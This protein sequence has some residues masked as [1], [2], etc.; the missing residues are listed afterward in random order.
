[1]N[2]FDATLKIKDY[3]Y[4]DNHAFLKINGE[5]EHSNCG[6]SILYS[7]NKI[8]NV[9]DY[10]KITKLLG[11]NIGIHKLPEEEVISFRKI[12]C[13]V[14][15]DKDYLKNSV[16]NVN[17]KEYWNFLHKEFQFCDVMSY[18]I[19][20]CLENYFKVKGNLYDCKIDLLEGKLNFFKDKKILEIGAGYGYLP[21]ILKENS[22]NH[23][24]YYADIVKRFDHDNFIDVD[25]Y[26]LGK[27]INEKFDVIVMFDV[28]QHLGFKVIETYF[29][30]FKNLLND[31]GK[32]I[33]DTPTLCNTTIASF[34]Y[35]Q[36]YYHPSLKEFERI[37]SNNYF[38]YQHQESYCNNYKVSEF[39]IIENIL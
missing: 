21:K 13:N 35:A 31:N 28:F 18:P 30:D 29:E 15:K 34:F 22:I 3:V 36:T 26:S 39:Y 33:I 6:L 9:N 25:G 5:L 2:I 8:K 10:L 38:K 4:N 1:M 19:F 14:L 17:T 12:D 23:T 20:P 16:D 7:R 37:L 32:I 24:Y 27:F 11:K